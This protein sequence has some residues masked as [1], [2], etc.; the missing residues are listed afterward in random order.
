[1]LVLLS[2]A[3]IL[4]DAHIRY[5]DAAMLPSCCHHDA[6][7]LTTIVT[8]DD[9][10]GRLRLAGQASEVKLWAKESVTPR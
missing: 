9:P 3:T 2:W 10:E 4:K 1:M 6:V 8:G 7:M 5:D